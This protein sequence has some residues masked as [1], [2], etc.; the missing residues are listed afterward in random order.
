MCVPSVAPKVR[1][2]TPDIDPSAVPK[3]GPD[4]V[5]RLQVPRSIVGGQL[6]LYPKNKALADL[7]LRVTDRLARMEESR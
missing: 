7:Y 4:L 1:N 5:S 2:L 6:A 3:Q